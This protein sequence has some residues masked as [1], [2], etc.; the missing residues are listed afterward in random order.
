MF[1]NGETTELGTRRQDSRC[2]VF[3]D[4]GDL[5]LLS[6]SLGLA[7]LYYSSASH[8]HP[9]L[10]AAYRPPPL[11][12]HTTAHSSHIKLNGFTTT[13]MFSSF[14]K[15]QSPNC[16]CS[17]LVN[18]STIH[19]VTPT[20]ETWRPSLP[21]YPSHAPHLLGHHHQVHPRSNSDIC[22]GS[23]ACRYSFISGPLFSF[24]GH[25]S[26]FLIDLP[27]THPENSC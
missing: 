19:E 4:E 22:L 15:S 9:V 3:T 13:L 14:P 7:S 24:W 25:C 18:D 26:I 5:D 16:S 6:V 2:G 17:D 27:I 20:R 23:S 12:R 1:G 8:C 21:W 10:S 11:G